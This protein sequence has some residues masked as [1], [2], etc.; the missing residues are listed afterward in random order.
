LVILQIRVGAR[1]IMIETTLH[2]LEVFT[3]QVRILVD[4]PIVE[5]SKPKLNPLAELLQNML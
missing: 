5:K 4:A 1:I 2:A 3:T